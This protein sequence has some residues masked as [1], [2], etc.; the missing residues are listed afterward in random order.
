MIDTSLMI[1]RW[2]FIQ[3]AFLPSEMSEK[4]REALVEKIK[5]IARGISLRGKEC[6]ICGEDSIELLDKHHLVLKSKYADRKD[7]NE[8]ITPLCKNHHNLAHE[9]IYKGRT[10]TK[11]TRDKMIGN[12]QW[13]RLVELDRMAAKALAGIPYR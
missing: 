11:H 10:V 9:L 12:G 4:K 1:G 8:H 13:T 6:F 5:A 7:I 3:Q 2:R